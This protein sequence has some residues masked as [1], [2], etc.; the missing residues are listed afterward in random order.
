[1]NTSDGCAWCG[2]GEGLCT[3]HMQAIFAQSEALA[4]T[5]QYLAPD[6]GKHAQPYRYAAHR[7]K[8]ALARAYVRLR[9]F[10]ARIKAQRSLRWKLKRAHQ[11]AAMMEGES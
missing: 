11:A 8:H 10:H 2:T 7:K 5:G 3:S 4:A 9:R 1:M 6:D